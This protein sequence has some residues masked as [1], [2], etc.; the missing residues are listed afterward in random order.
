ML[1]PIITVRSG[2]AP[3][4][5]L[6]SLEFIQTGE[7]TDALPVRVGE[8]SDP[9]TFRIYNNFDCAPSVTDAMEVRVNVYDNT[10][11]GEAS[12]PTTQEWMHCYETMY[13]ESTGAGSLYTAYTGEDTAVG[14]NDS[15]RPEYGSSGASGSTIRAGSTSDG[16]GFIEIEA[17][18]RPS[19]QASTMIYSFMVEI[20][21][22]YIA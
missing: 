17:R 10:T 3:Y 22:E 16:Q 19:A 8:D 4:P 1:A 2:T 6:S 9:T 21:Y 14:G 12:L 18:C 15:Y 20:S 5:L 7:Y 13:G 11:Y